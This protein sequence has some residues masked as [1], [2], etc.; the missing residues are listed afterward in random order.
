M[1]NY[2]KYQAVLTF[3]LKKAEQYESGN[4]GS[5]FTIDSFDDQLTYYF[6]SAFNKI[7]VQPTG[8]LPITGISWIL[9]YYK[10]LLD[11]VGIEVQARSRMEYN[12]T[13]T[14]FT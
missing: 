1:N 8:Q 9:P 7:V 10:K 3:N 5:S 13:S 12:S 6:A 14:P 2:R 4:W 11:K